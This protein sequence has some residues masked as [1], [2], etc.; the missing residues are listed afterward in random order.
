MTTP[1]FLDS[2]HKLTFKK[3]AM[4]VK[5]TDDPAAWQREIAS[6]V[7]KQLPFLGEYAVNV[8]LERVDAQRGYA[9][10]SA[11]VTNHSQAPTPEQESLPSVRIPII[12]RERMMMP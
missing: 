11:Q 7:Y 3:I 6:E 5:L 10:G 9:L 4:P 8:V 12:V 2:E 1:L